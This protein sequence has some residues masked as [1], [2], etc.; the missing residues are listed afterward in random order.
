MSYWLKSLV[1]CATVSLQKISFY[2]DFSPK[3]HNDIT[4]NIDQGKV[5]ALILIDLSAALHG[6]RSVGDGGGGDASPPPTFQG[7]GTA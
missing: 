4:L 6:R 5:T 3:V 7:G 1:Q 2:I